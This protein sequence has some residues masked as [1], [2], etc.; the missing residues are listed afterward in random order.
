MVAHDGRHLGLCRTRSSSRGGTGSGPAG[1]SRASG[2][3]G[4]EPRES[5]LAG[6]ARKRVRDSRIRQGRLLQPSRSHARDRRCPSHAVG[7]E[8]PEMRT[9]RE[10]A[11]SGESQIGPLHQGSSAGRAPKGVW[12]PRKAIRE[13]N[14]GR[15]PIPIG[16]REIPV[17]LVDR[18]DCR[19]RCGARCHAKAGRGHSADG[20]RPGP[21]KSSSF[22]EAAAEA[23]LALP[24]R[25]R[26]ERDR[27]RQRLVRDHPLA[28]HAR[29]VE[30]SPGGPRSGAHRS[31]QRWSLVSHWET[32]GHRRP[33]RS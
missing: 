33:C 26:E 23:G 11:R 21:M 9:H 6:W 8:A 20:R 15:R 4:G 12:P 13:G 16:V 3:A 25:N 24:S 7:V 29:R 31:E 30:R 32:E 27:G 1:T 2:I 18:T 22:D 19:R 14:L 5:R 10:S 17:V 28:E